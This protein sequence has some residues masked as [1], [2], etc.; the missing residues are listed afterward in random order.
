MAK[1][2]L[3]P[4]RGG[5]AN[6][7]CAHGQVWRTIVQIHQYTKELILLGE[8]REPD[9]KS[10]LQPKQEHWHAYDHVIRAMACE[11]G[12]LEGASKDY[13]D[14][15]YK[16]VLGHEYRAFFDAADF[17]CVKIRKR[18]IE[19][20]APFD[21]IFLSLHFP[22]YHSRIRRQIDTISKEIA[23]LRGVKDV[24]QDDEILQVVA[25][26][27]KTVQKLLD[28]LDEVEQQVPVLYESM[29]SIR[30]REDELRRREEDLK[31]K[32][33]EIERRMKQ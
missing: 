8:E 6:L 19:A 21:D 5:F 26:Y 17:L 22:E 3:L 20:L 12:L 10:F 27:R 28:L 25:R 11:V 2:L 15:H 13:A 29:K 1:G 7:R 9:F 18:V 24:G 30:S 32:E 14:K 4:P 31:R 33:E 16:K 23:G